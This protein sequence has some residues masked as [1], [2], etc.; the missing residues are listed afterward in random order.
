VD[1]KTDSKSIALLA[2]F[3]AIIIVLEIFPVTG[4]TDLKFYPGGTQFTLDWTGIPIIIV[5]VG[6][7]IISSL[8][9]IG[10]M[11]FAINFHGNFPGSVFKGIAEIFTIIGVLIAKIISDKKALGKKASASL[12]LIFGASTR[13]IGMFFVNIPLL[14]IFYPLSYGTTDLAIIASTVLIPWNILQ[15]GINILGG[16]VLYQLIPENLRIQAGFEKHQPDEVKYEEL[17]EDELRAEDE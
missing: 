7:G 3:S 11:F 14:S 5:F 8:I 4:L 12:Y 16:L 2:V 9:S 13:T 1:I 10:I 17:S 15:A 6:L